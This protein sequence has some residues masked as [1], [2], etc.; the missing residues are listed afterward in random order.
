MASFLLEQTSEVWN[1]YGPTETTIWAT[2]YKVSSEDR[3][4]LIGK[5]IDNASIHIFDESL[6]PVSVGD[7]GELFIGGKGVSLGYWNRPELNSERFLNLRLED[8]SIEQVYKTG[9]LCCL[10]E[11]GNL[12]YI[13]RS[14]FQVKIRGFRIELVRN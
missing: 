4:P 11:D 2:L 3:K 13:G 6:K 12:E 14:D 5:P 7:V 8:G 1:V 9:D 10:H